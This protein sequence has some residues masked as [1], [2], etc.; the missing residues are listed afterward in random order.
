MKI[1]KLT[2]IM[3]TLAVLM[4]PA[5]ASAG[6]CPE[7]AEQCAR[8]MSEHFKQRGWVGINMDID[9]ETGT[10]TVTNVV[11]DSPAERSGFQEGDVLKALN[12][13]AYTTENEAAL[14]TE[15]ESFRPGGTAVFTVNRGGE[16]LDIEVHLEAIPDAILAQWIGQHILE[17]H[18][19]ETDVET[20]G[21][22]G[23]DGNP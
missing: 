9:E 20:E 13:V 22:T 4:V 19:V 8:Q 10:V 3:P 5:W 11:Q 18:T 15:H 17:Y 23:S 14:K 12:G 2:V 7:T 6:T 21:D 1:Y 16:K